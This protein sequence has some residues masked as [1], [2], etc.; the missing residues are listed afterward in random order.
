MFWFV[1]DDVENIILL[2]D[3]NFLIF[4]FF[5]VLFGIGFF[6]DNKWIYLVIRIFLELY[7]KNEEKFKDFYIKKK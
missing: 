6:W 4:N 5:M 3:V 1:E 7:V 2:L